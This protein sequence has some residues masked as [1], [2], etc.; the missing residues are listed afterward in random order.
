[1][2]ILS[3]S[4][5]YTQRMKKGSPVSIVSVYFLSISRSV[6]FICVS[7]SGCINR[8]IVTVAVIIGGQL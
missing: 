7:V 6:Q 8:L 4:N 5:R 3:S 1:M 2:L